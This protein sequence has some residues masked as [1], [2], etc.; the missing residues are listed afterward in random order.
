MEHPLRS[1]CLSA[2]GSLLCAGFAAAQTYSNNTTSIPQGNPFN[3]SYSENVDFADVDLDGDWDAAFAD[4]GDSN[5]DQNRLWINQGFA[6]A[7]TLGFFLDE[8]ATRMPAVTDESR[9]IEFVDFDADGD[10]DLYAS[11]TST[12]TNETNR[13]LTNQ[14]GIQA[15]STGFYVDDTATRWVGLGGAG[16][17]IAPAQVLGG[18][19]FI[20]FSCDCD[21]GD[22]DNDGDMD[23]VHSS[24]GGVFGGQVPTRL[25][26]NDGT[27]HFSE[28]NPSGFQLVGQTI[29]NGNP[30]LWCSGTQQANTT[31]T[32]GQQCDIASTALDI[33][34]GDIDRDL[35]LD[36]L[37]GAR[38]ELPRMFVNGLEKGFLNWKDNTGA[39]F[40]AGY[41]VGDGHYEQ[42]M[43]DFDGDGDIDIYGLNWRVTLPGTLTDVTLENDGTGFFHNRADLPG[44]NSDD[45]EAD[46]VDYDNDGDVDVFVAAFTSHDRLYRNN[47]NGGATFSFTNVTATELPTFTP[48]TALDADACDVDNDGDYDAFTANDLFGSGTGQNVY[49]RNDSN[50]PDTTAPGL[51]DLEQAKDRIAGAAP[52]VIRVRVLD[53]APYYTTWYN[54]TQ[55]EVTVDGGSPVMYPMRSSGGEIFRGEIPGNLVGTI[56]YKAISKD[57]QL[58]TGMS[59]QLCF[60]AYPSSFC[61]ASDNALASCPCSNPGNPDTGCDI[62]DS[63]GGVRMDVLAQETVPSNHATVMGVGYPTAGSPGAVVIRATSLDSASPVVFGDGL[64][65]IGTPLVRLGASLAS[66][67]TSLHTFGHGT[68][69][70]AGAFFYQIWFRN[71]PIMFCDPAA[72]FNLSNGRV[73]L[74]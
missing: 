14:G 51:W 52:T 67:G 23:L 41:S 61:D 57:K 35:D 44:S 21:F 42:E 45:N 62:A 47:N 55:L 22:I 66:G 18:G 63:S 10:V 4:G 71:T 31:N 65:C 64:R 19:G 13:W 9:D 39:A 59:G 29:A 74:W 50:V 26:L 36:I 24:Y 34:L 58:N 33:D 54:D 56:C 73:L 70:G 28:F 25:F 43:G 27:G 38:Q 69:A 53:N 2:L 17:S 5:N 3:N 20:D 68:G 32:T 1:L 48:R 8:T 15:G 30:G 12:H 40:E 16:S 37:H 7:G 60:T 11:N 49:Y 6:Q 72:A 46:M